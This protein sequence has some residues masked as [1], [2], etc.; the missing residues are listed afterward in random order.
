MKPEDMNALPVQDVMDRWPETV[1][2][3]VRR[4]MN[5]PGC[6]M[7]PLMSVAEAAESYET[8]ADAL[9]VE[10]IAA[11]GAVETGGGTS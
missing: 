9:A 6:P 11:I 8:Q 4:G 10:L 2:V 5:C 1:P 7:A 3:F